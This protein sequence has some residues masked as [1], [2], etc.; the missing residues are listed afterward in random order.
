MIANMLRRIAGFF[1]GIAI[2][3]IVLLSFAYI[4]S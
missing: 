2:G 1:I 4:A 3:L